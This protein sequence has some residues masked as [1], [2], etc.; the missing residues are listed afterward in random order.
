MEDT[1][2]T[3]CEYWLLIKSKGFAG[4]VLL[5][6]IIWT[7]GCV[8]LQPTIFRTIEPNPTIV[9]TWISPT[10][11]SHLPSPSTN[12][13]SPTWSQA[14]LPLGCSF[15]SLSPDL[16]W[17]V[18]MG[19]PSASGDMNLIAQVD[20]DGM[21][22]NPRQLESRLVPY[23]EGIGIMGFTP[24]STQLIL[25]RG[26]RYWLMNLMDLTQ[27]PSAQD[28]VGTS[29]IEHFGGD[30]WSP[31]GR[32]WLSPDCWGC[33]QVFVASPSDQTKE[34]ILDDIG[35]HGAQFN[36]S[37]DGRAIVH[38]EG[39]YHESMRACVIDLQTRQVR[40]LIER[41]Y[42]ATLTGASYSPDG[43]WIAIREQSIES[44]GDTRL[45]LIDVKTGTRVQLAYKLFD[46]EVYYGW[47][48]LVWS[49]DSA[50]LALRG[51]GENSAGFVVI[52]IPSGKIAYRG[53]GKT[54]GNPLAWSTDGRSLLVLDFHE[55]PNSAMGSF[56]L[57]W[58]Q[59]E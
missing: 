29:G 26:K 52:E 58:V 30:R 5:S 13:L 53:T 3:T 47:Q 33:G 48:D 34:Q 20:K 36:W 56:I 19:C 17:V 21:L 41:P 49:P 11:T 12:A 42:P 46:V 24:D 59:M 16:H 54:S 45:W 38:I 39:D 25:E 40:T 57:R 9:P 7:S 32:F 23:N 51:M 55:E 35:Q 27:V 31:N 43:R 8:P 1:R 14:E 4:C 2:H 18:M 50:R 6:V 22:Y 10:A 28:V 44:S 15:H 37:A